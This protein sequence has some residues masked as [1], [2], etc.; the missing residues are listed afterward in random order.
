[1][2][3]YYQRLAGA[4]RHGIKVALRSSHYGGIT[5]IVLLPRKIMVSEYDESSWLTHGPLGELPPAAPNGPAHEAGTHEP[6]FGMTG[7]HHRLPLPGSSPEADPAGGSEVAEAAEEPLTS[8][9][10]QLQAP[11]PPAQDQ[12]PQAGSPMAAAA[13]WPTSP[14]EPTRPGPAVNG[15]AVGG[16]HLGLPRR[17]RLASLA[18][19]LRSHPGRAVPGQ[20]AAPA[21]R[22]PEQTSSLM[23][24][25]QAGLLRGRL[26]D[27]DSPDACPESSG[28]RPGG[29]AG[30]EAEFD[31]REVES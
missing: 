6:A 4:D 14:A 17:V 10:P 8:T 22:S 3:P 27:L 16:T 30:A 1:M 28:G 9:A 11:P 20:P 18:P 7:R 23:S 19:Q 21:A 25:L 15:A 5:A 2:F 29:A 12:P 24:A 31:D 26:D 13:A